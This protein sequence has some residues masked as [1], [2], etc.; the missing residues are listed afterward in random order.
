MKETAITD[1]WPIVSGSTRAAAAFLAA[2]WAT[3]DACDIAAA[4]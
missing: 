1:R 4:G 3:L 2:L